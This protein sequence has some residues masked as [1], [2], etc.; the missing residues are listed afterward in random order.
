MYTSR[1][2]LLP[3]AEGAPPGG[4]R[5]LGPRY[6]VRRLGLQRGKLEVSAGE[7]QDRQ[8]GTEEIKLQG[9]K[10][11]CPSFPPYTFLGFWFLLLSLKSCQSFPTYLKLQL[12]K[13][14]IPT[15]SHPA[16]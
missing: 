13:T 8:K 14:A 16:T 11:R 10:V 5:K 1:Y 15:P 12:P 7:S 4:P 3:T 9:G 6:L 2:P